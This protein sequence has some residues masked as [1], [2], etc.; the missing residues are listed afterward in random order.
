MLI[1]VKV[2]KGYID[3]INALL[4]SDN[5]NLD[6]LQEIVDYIENNKDLIDSITT[7]KISYTDIIDNLTSAIAGKP[8]SA[9]QGKVLKDL[10]DALTTVVGNKANSSDVYTKSETYARTEVDTKMLV[11][12]ALIVDEYNNDT[13]EITFNYQS[14]AVTPSYADTTGIL[15]LT[16]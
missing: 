7:N 6:S 1:K 14:G 9:N 2:L 10:V 8:L 12:G 16:Y 13:G 15:T 11:A 5:I 3:A 4:G